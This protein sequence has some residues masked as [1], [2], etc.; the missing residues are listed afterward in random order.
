M[1]HNRGSEQEIRVPFENM[2][3]QLPVVAVLVKVVVPEG[4][5][6]G[7]VQDKLVVVDIPV[8]EAAVPADAALVPVVQGMSGFVVD[9]LL[10]AAAQEEPA[11][12]V[13]RVVRVAPQL[14]EVKLR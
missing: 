8:Q 3:Y 6:P 2:F 5:V 14:G 12:P 7:I 4:I 11:V 13:D 10:E 9:R 1:E